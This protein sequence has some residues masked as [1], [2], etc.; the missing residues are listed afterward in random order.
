[1][2]REPAVSLK[3]YLRTFD[4]IKD[5]RLQ[6]IDLSLNFLDLNPARLP[7]LN[8]VELNSTNV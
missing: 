6:Q 3:Y 8:P 2:K 5:S 1:M 4:E 7:E